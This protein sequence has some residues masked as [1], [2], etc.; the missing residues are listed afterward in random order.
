M[1]IRIALVLAA[2]TI[3]C[4]EPTVAGRIDRSDAV[5]SA[6]AAYEKGDYA[7]AVDFLKTAESEQPANGEVYLLLTKSYYQMQERDKAVDSGEKAVAIDPNNSEYHEWLGRAYGEKADHSSWFSALGLAKKSRK[8]FE[9]AVQLNDRNFS[10]MQALI[11]Y[12]CIAPG[13]AGGGEDKALTEID[14]VAK[15]DVAE[16]HYARGNC[17]RQKKDFGTADA[18]FSKA[19]ESNPTSADLIF[20]IGDYAMKRSQPEMLE[21]VAATGSKV[22]QN[23]PRGEFYHALSLILRKTKLAEAEQKLRKYLQTAPPRDNYPSASSAHLWLGLTM[24]QQND[25][26]GARNEYE[27]ALKLDPKNKSAN[28]ALKKLA[29]N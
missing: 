8:E 3:L 25:I 26:A 27:T 4:G 2:A 1:T 23:D 10:A 28:E 20:D 11:E 22:K 13:I 6:S 18:E 16:G 17:R 9:K 5:Q 21:Q 12:D 24:E 14:Q 19:L 7:R 15:L 29:K